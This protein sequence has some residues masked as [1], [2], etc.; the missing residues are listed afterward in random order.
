M[1]PLPVK[2][3]QLIG[4]G[5]FRVFLLKGSLSLSPERK[6]LLGACG[7]SNPPKKSEIKLNL[8]EPPA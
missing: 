5:F 8:E 1:G 2:K 4:E 7:F 3:P 6:K